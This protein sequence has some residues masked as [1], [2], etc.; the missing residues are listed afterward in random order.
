M[1]TIV[2]LRVMART[3]DAPTLHHVIASALAAL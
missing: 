3:Y 1:N 2:G